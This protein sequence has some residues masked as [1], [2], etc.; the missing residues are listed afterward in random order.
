M[1]KLDF[2]IREALNAGYTASD[3]AKDLS[4]TSGYDYEAALKSGYSDDEIISELTGAKM[5]TAFESV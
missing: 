5:P 1:A 3:I 2:D 4:E